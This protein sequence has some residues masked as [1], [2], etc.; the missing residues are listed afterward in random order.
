MAKVTGIGGVFLRSEAPDRLAG[1]YRRRL[2]IPVSESGHH[3]F[4]WRHEDAPDRVGRTV[5]SVFPADTDYFGDKRVRFMVNFRVDD[6]DAV[7]ESLRAAGADVDDRIAEYDYGRF[8]WVT[9]PEGNRI[10]LWEPAGESAE[11]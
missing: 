5:W 4:R 1:W 9:D 2:G 7:L 6:L 11:S 3:E 8:G 10:E